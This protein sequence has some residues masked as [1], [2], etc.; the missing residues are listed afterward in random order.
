MVYEGLK[1]W[2][3]EGRTFPSLHHSEN[4]RRGEE[5]PLSPA[6]TPA[7]DKR[8]AHCSH[9]PAQRL[10]HKLYLAHLRPRA[11]LSHTAP[12]PAPPGNATPSGT[13]SS[14]LDAAAHSGCSKRFLRPGQCRA[15]T[16][17]THSPARWLSLPPHPWYWSHIP[18]GGREGGSPPVE[19]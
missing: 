19:K 15:P 9:P 1:V 16:P 18:T 10:Q 12:A 13:L 8:N 14:K 5:M 7:P 17:G 3:G 4:S 6:P 11:F 2:L